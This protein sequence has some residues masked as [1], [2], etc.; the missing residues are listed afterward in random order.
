M[1]WFWGDLSHPILNKLNLINEIVVS[2]ADQ[3]PRVYKRSKGLRRYADYDPSKLDACLKAMEDGMSQRL[4]SEVFGI[5][6]STLKY[7]KM[8]I[9]L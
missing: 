6:R 2:A 1:A 5:P 7:K 9:I 4:A 8:E 3:M